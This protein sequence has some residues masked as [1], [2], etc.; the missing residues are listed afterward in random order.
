MIWGRSEE[1]GIGDTWAGAEEVVA[2]GNHRPCKNAGRGLEYSGKTWRGGESIGE[3]EVLKGVSQ[4]AVGTQDALVLQN[5]GV[6]I[7]NQRTTV[8]QFY[9]FLR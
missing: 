8:E 9:T 2:G 6:V 7:L 1:R 5:A 4:E 3:W